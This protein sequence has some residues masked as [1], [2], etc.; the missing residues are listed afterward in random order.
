MK[1]LVSTLLVMLCAISATAQTADRGGA[2]GSFSAE[3]GC[4]IAFTKPQYNALTVTANFGYHFD[5]KWS[6]HLP[7][8]GNTTLYG[9]KRYDNQ[10]LIGLA[11]EY[12]FGRKEQ[13]YWSVSPKVQ[14]SCL[15]DWGYMLY[16]VGVKCH[17]G[18]SPYVGLGIQFQDSYK[19][20]QGYSCGL[21]VSFGFR[22]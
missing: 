16:E 19:R 17:M 7:I 6:I 10:L 4:Q 8:S 2:H 1:K 14:A 22:L 3:T 5:D 9:D 20:E 21:Y 12:A 15:G 13:I 11:P 18:K